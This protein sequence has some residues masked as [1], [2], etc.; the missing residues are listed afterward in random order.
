MTEVLEHIEFETKYRVEE[1]LL[2]PFKELVES[3][4]GIKK[5]IYVQ[6]TDEY[7]TSELGLARYRRE[8]F[9]KTGRAEVTFKD[10]P[11]GASSNIIRKE[12][13][14]RVDH[15]KPKDIKAG[16]EMRG[17]KFNFKIWKACHVYNFEEVTLVCYSV[18]D[19]ETKELAHFLEIEVAEGKGLTEEQSWNIIKKYEEILTPLGITSRN[20]LRKS[21]FE[22]YKRDL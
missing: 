16:L 6:G 19:E 14:W 9:S 17:Y 10:K 1:S 18:R 2:L 8:E 5:F 12:V 22:M 3:L 13:N 15:T 7:Y 20:R 11:V 4:E 21:L